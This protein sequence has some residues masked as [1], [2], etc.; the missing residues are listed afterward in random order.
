V[1]DAASASKIVLNDGEE[2]TAD[3]TLTAVPALRFRL[4][5]FNA[6]PEQ[7]KNAILQQKV[8]GATIDPPGQRQTPVDD[9]VEISGVP[10]GKYALKVDSYVPIPATRMTVVNLT[11]DMD[12]DADSASPPSLITGV[13]RIHDNLNLRPQAF[14]RLWNSRT[15]EILDAQIAQNGEFRFDPDFLGPGS[16]SVFVVN[17]ENS[18]ISSL[19]ADGAQVVG[20]SIQITGSKPIR[21][22][23][24]LSTTLSAIDGIVRRNGQ[25]FLGAMVL[26][27]PENPEINLPL[28]RRDQSDSDGTFRLRDVLPGRYRILAIEDGWDMEW[29]KPGLL[30]SR[31]DH[32]ETIEVQPNKTY[33]TSVNVE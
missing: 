1:T 25:P 6:N 4:T 27:V 5:H 16:Y 9:S 21:L 32:A 33:Q 26:L 11:T 24:V 7:P 13:I 3:F 20:Q 18:I 17:G 23:I 2:F 12:F 19:S 22:S 14:V 15:H 30:N 8:F 29:A 31:L 28:F 10:P